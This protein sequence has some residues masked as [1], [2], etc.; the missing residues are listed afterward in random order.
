[1]SG[2]ST[3]VNYLSGQTVSLSPRDLVL[4]KQPR[5]APFYHLP[6]SSVKSECPHQSFYGAMLPYDRASVGLQIHLHSKEKKEVLPLHDRSQN[7]YVP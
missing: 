6:K 3:G 7:T 1:M 4:K 2:G 5:K